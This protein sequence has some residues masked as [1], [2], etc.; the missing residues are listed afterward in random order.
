MSSDVWWLIVLGFI[1]IWCI[2]GGA[3]DAYERAHATPTCDDWG[4]EIEDLQRRVKALEA[5]NGS[6]L[7]R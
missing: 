3:I 7:G 5:K 1:V 2:A 4:D 6:G